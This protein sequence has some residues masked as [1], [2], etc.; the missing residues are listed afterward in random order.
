MFNFDGWGFQN[1]TWKLARRSRGEDGAGGWSRKI[2]VV[3]RRTMQQI[4]DEGGK[5]EDA[6]D[7]GTAGLPGRQAEALAVAR[8]ARC[9]TGVTLRRDRPLQR[10]SGAQTRTEWA[11]PT[12]GFPLLEEQ[13]GRTPVVPAFQ[14][15][16][17]AQT[18]TQAMRGSRK[19]PS[20]LFE[21]DKRGTVW[22]SASGAGRRQGQ[23]IRQ[24][25]GRPGPS[26]DEPKLGV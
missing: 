15:A 2:G 16:E 12:P 24:S 14:R 20:V 22:L 4:E 13:D 3:C 1:E 18:T 21:A 7:H 25:M 8:W 5:G 19:A 26:A 23:K 10:W 11:W 6:A 9:P 17:L